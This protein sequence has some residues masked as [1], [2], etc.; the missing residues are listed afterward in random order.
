MMD[1]RERVLKGAFFP[2][3]D[4][5]SPGRFEVVCRTVNEDLVALPMALSTEDKFQR[6]L[7]RAE[8]GDELAVRPG[9]HRLNG[10]RAHSSAASSLSRRPLNQY[11]ASVSAP[12]D[13]S[14]VLMICA[15]DGITPA[16]Q[17][18][19]RF[20]SGSTSAAAI[21]ADV[22][23]EGVLA[24]V[25]GPSA[26]QAG[27]DEVNL[28]W[29]NDREEDFVCQEEIDHFELGHSNKFTVRRLL[30]DDLFSPELMRDRRIYTSMSPY[31]PGDLA[32]I[33]AQEHLVEQ[34]RFLL[35]ELGYPHEA[36]VNVVM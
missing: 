35:Q 10:P 16:V 8:I 18:M 19:K 24:D 17:L 13:V 6:A 3:T 20:L 34:F 7:S 28:V 27:V 33:C 32:V 2:V 15:G 9:K 31:A 29:L 5:T 36:I 21:S 4:A 30:E 12:P 14:R 25:V 11:A 1:N 22:D 23:G 26:A